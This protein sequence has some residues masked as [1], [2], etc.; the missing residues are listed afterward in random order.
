[1]LSCC[2]EKQYVQ[3]KICAPWNATGDDATPVVIT[4]FT[5]NLSNNIYGSGYLQYDVGPDAITLTVLDG[6]GN[7][8]YTTTLDPGTSISFTYRRFATIQLTLPTTAGTY[9]GEFCITTRYSL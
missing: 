1:M 4:V 2:P 9:Q 5:N 7:T 8:L 3:D 6:V